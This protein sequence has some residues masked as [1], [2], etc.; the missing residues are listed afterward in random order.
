M[1]EPRSRLRRYRLLERA[2]LLPVEMRCIGNRPLRGA[3]RVLLREAE[4]VGPGRLGHERRHEQRRWIVPATLDRARGDRRRRGAVLR[5]SRAQAHHDR[6]QG[7]REDIRRVRHMAGIFRREEPA[8][9]RRPG[10]AAR[11]QVQV[12]NRQTRRSNHDHRVELEHSGHAR[13]QGDISP[14]WSNRDTTQDGRGC[15]GHPRVQGPRVRLHPGTVHRPR[16][17]ADRRDDELHR[18]DDTG[19]PYLRVQGAMPEHVGAVRDEHKRLVEDVH[20]QRLR[21]EERRDDGEIRRA[22]R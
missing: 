2:L 22:L 4:D 8:L 15:V 3:R 14:C 1:H 5:T 16:P 11:V 9:A 21:T 13:L 6:R 10:R 12:P 20:V 19:G 7:Q 17:M 18:Q